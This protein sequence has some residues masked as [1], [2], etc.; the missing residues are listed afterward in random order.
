MHQ[1]LDGPTCPEN[2]KN[3]SSRLSKRSFSVTTGLI[4]FMRVTIG[5]L[6]RWEKDSIQISASW[7]LAS[8]SG[9]SQKPTVFFSLLRLIIDKSEKNY[10]IFLFNYNLIFFQTGVN[11]KSYAC[12]GRLEW[13]IIDIYPCIKIMIVQKFQ[14]VNIKNDS[15]RS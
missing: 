12:R 15:S 11:W 7:F 14:K 3:D 5:N 2:V 6:T 9:H 10:L 8:K 13:I 4:S 1:N